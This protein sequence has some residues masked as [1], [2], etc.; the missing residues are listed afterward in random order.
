MRSLQQLPLA[1]QRSIGYA[2]AMPRLSQMRAKDPDSGETF[3]V[4]MLR[5]IAGECEP[6]G[7]RH[8]PAH[9]QCEHLL[10]MSLSR[11]RDILSW[12]PGDCDAVR[13]NAMVQVIRVVAGIASKASSRHVDRETEA[14][15]REVIEKM[16]TTNS[17]SSD[18]PKGEDVS[19]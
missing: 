2:R 1:R 13:L 11:M 7:W 18:A 16:A 10:G 5:S 4:P 17:V 8:W 6:V 3:Y 14:R 12:P 9:Q 19:R 15:F